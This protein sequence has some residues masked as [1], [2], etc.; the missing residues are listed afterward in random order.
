VRS[1]PKIFA[2]GHKAVKELL[3]GEVVVQ[4]KIDGSQ[5]SFCLKS[6]KL[7]MRSKGAVIDPDAPP[8]LFS[9][10]VAGIKEIQDKLHPGWSYRGEQLS[11]LKHNTIEYKR[12]PKRHF[13][14][15]DVDTGME[16]FLTP[17]EMHVEAERLGVSRVALLGQFPGKML[18]EKLIGEMIDGP[19][20]LGGVIEGIVIKA[21]G[22]FGEDKK[23]LMGKFVKEEFKEA[24]RAAW[25]K[26]NPSGK[27]VVQKLIEGLR[28]E[29]RWE[30]AVQH[31]R[32][33]GFLVDEPKDIG[34]LFKE[35]N[36]DVLEEEK[37]EIEVV[38][39]KWAWKDVSRGI[40]AGL[41]EW[42]KR[43]LMKR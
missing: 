1:Y 40:T 43:E 36:R 39:F 9:S 17:R 31:L 10:V 41:A 29:A 37:S 16:D 13:V 12:L 2:L 4:E 6:G 15:F 27:D 11:K 34:L 8:S 18:T 28:T 5:F 23:T 20:T 42:Y 38:L 30:K 25:S 24:H 21:Y 22:R 33:G 7:E 26:T 32:D 14:L 19:S 35:V 3:D